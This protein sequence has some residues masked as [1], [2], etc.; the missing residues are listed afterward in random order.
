M[1]ALTTADDPR[2]PDRNAVWSAVK[3]AVEEYV[4]AA[5]PPLKAPANH[6]VT[7]SSAFLYPVPFNGIH[8]EEL[9]LIRKPD[10]HPTA[11]AKEKVVE[12]KEDKSE[13]KSKTE[14][15]VR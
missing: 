9:P 12:A 7:D 5:T 4:S 8:E 11:Q 1:L 2:N 13:E 10:E 15:V 3:A 14:E 6:A